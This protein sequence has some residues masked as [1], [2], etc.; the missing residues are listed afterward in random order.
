MRHPRRGRP[1]RW[2][3]ASAAAL[4]H[5]PPAELLGRRAP[6]ARRRPTLPRGRLLGRR[7]RRRRTCRT[8]AQ[9]YMRNLTSWGTQVGPYE[10]CQTLFCDFLFGGM[11]HFP[12]TACREMGILHLI[13]KL[14][15]TEGCLTPGNSNWTICSPQNQFLQ[16]EFPLY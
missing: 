10:G 8:A 12:F 6:L 11:Q 14:N 7:R 9:W 16:N 5:A 15:D 3:V 1:R 13:S 2:T 4:A